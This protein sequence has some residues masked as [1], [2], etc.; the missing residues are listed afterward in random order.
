MCEEHQAVD[1]MADS[2]VIRL[3][4][5][6]RTVVDTDL[7]DNMSRVLSHAA[8]EG[9]ISYEKAEEITNG[10]PDDTLLKAFEYR[11]LIPEK[12]RTGTME[13]DDAILTFETGSV[14][15]IPNVVKYLVKIAELAGEWDPDKAI[16]QLFQESYKAGW[17]LMPQLVSRLGSLADSFIIDAYTIKEACNEVGLD[18][19]IDLMIAILKG[20]GVIS[21]RLGSLARRTRSTSP[22]YELNPSLFLI[23][24]CEISGSVNR[25]TMA[26]GQRFKEEEAKEAARVLCTATSKDC[27]VYQEIDLPIDVKQ[28]LVVLL[29]QE[30]L[31]ISLTPSFGGGSAWQ[32]RRLCFEM[33]ERYQVLPVVRCLVQQAM[34]SGKWEIATAEAECIREA[35]RNIIEEILEYLKTLKQSASNYIVSPETMRA[36]AFQLNLKLDL[37][38]TIDDFTRFGIISPPMKASLRSGLALYEINPTLCWS[39]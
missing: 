13:W 36:V 27:I 3:S 28:E 17:S 7:T 38:D 35:G 15:K 25:L 39:C 34:K 33:E 29:H 2:S 20:S 9:R 11:M 1:E 19:Q 31:L 18:S 5:A 21:P 30:R 6:L 26:L 23:R 22:L 14:F 10:N 16:Q 24:T 12:S 4:S 8:E 32:D 37:H